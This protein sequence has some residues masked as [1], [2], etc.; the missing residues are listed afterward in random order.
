MSFYLKQ[1][2]VSITLQNVRFKK[3]KK[4]D[5]EELISVIMKIGR[6]QYHQ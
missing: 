6:F 3:K 5:K 4:L 2:C 1:C